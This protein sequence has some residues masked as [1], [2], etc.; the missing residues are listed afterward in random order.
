[1]CGSE[2]VCECECGWGERGGDENG[3]GDVKKKRMREKEGRGA[4]LEDCKR[5]WEERGGSEKGWRRDLKSLKSDK[6]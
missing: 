3:G 5:M 4:S 1:M 2:R 6:R